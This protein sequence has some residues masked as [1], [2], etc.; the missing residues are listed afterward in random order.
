MQ[1]RAA[2]TTLEI[3]N[4]MATTQLFKGRIIENSAVVLL[5]RV[6][7]SMGTLIDPDEISTIVAKVWDRLTSTL[8]ATNTLS[9]NDCVYA[10]LQEG[11]VRW[12]Q[13]DEGYNVEIKLDGSN[14]PEGDR[15]YRVE[16]K[17]DPADEYGAGEAF[18]LLWDL[19][20]VA[21][22]SE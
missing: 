11:D 20:S 4:S 22:L 14:F 8:V 3:N 12:T 19:Y 6:R 7:D 13:D 9:A 1:T 18:Y 16:V 5:A 2:F 15:T 21:V 10:E 17:I